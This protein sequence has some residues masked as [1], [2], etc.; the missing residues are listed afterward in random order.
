M[1]SK[2]LQV[3]E[4]IFMVLSIHYSSLRSFLCFLQS[5]YWLIKVGVGSEIIFQSYGTSLA[6]ETALLEGTDS[7]TLYSRSS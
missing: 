1:L 4:V 3:L 6:D 5:L 7:K 2:I